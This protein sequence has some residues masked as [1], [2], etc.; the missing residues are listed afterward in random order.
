[1]NKNRYAAKMVI[2]IFHKLLCMNQVN[3]DEL[4]MLMAFPTIQDLRFKM[5]KI[6][7][8]VT[9]IFI[10]FPSQYDILIRFPNIYMILIFCYK[11]FIQDLLTLPMKLWKLN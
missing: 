5:S 3:S 2:Q 1:M 9:K 6:I 4:K 7:L 8:L 11:T 10:G